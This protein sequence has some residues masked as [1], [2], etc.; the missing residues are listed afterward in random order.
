MD[1]E[2]SVWYAMRVTYRREMDV[3]E[4][5]DKELVESFIPMHYVLRFKGG[6][7]KKM[8]E[9]VVHNLIFVHATP[10]IIKGLKGKL[11]Y[12]QYM[13]EHKEQR[14]VPIIVPDRQMKHF[15]SIA[16]TYDEQLLFLDPQEINL[17]KGAKVRICGGLFDGKEGIYIKLK[18]IRDKRVVVAVPGVIAVAMA[19]LHTSQIE[20]IEANH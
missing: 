15:I 14:R 6:K 16:G 5:L 3:K 11:P 9:P 19:T 7:K 20:L 17:S 4:F 2:K 8:L 1:R 12:L 10:S 13:M 18:G